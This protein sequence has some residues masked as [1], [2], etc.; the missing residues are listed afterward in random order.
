MLV[1]ANIAPSWACG[2]CSR[3]V[4][5]WFPRDFR[6]ASTAGLHAS[7]RARF[8]RR[9]ADYL[10]RKPA[11]WAR[12]VLP[13]AS[14]AQYHDWPGLGCPSRGKL[15]GTSPGISVPSR[16]QGRDRMAKEKSPAS[17][18]DPFKAPPANVDE[19]TIA[20]ADMVPGASSKAAVVAILIEEA[21]DGVRYKNGRTMPISAKRLLAAARTKGIRPSYILSDNL[22]ASGETR[23]DGVAAHHIVAAGIVAPSGR[24]RDCSAGISPTT[25]RT[26]ASTCPGSSPPSWR[27]C[28][29]RPSI[30]ACIRGSTTWRYL[31]DCA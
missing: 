23:P 15:R 11:C 25:T 2:R 7:G 16:S 31:R 3:R 14:G 22:V 21:K 12:R 27:A 13:K 19:L 30:R 28:P 10:A 4:L 17:S 9:E 1:D 6:Q 8:A 5:S 29:T 24:R 26:T 18:I 20:A